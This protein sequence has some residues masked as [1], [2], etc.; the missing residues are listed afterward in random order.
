MRKFVCSWGVNPNRDCFLDITF[1]LRGAGDA[2]CKNF[3][4]SGNHFRVK[5][6]A[7]LFAQIR[8]RFFRR[9]LFPVRPFGGQCIERIRPRQRYAPP[10]EYLCLASRLDNRCHPSVPGDNG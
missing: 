1:Y 4:K 7:G 10:A 6:D 8:D 9:Y 3:F 5:Q 2:L